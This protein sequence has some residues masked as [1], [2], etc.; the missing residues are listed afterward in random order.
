[1]ILPIEIKVDEFGVNGI[2][3][4]IYSEELFPLEKYGLNLTSL[5]DNL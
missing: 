5:N 1:M 3:S 2:M 4:L